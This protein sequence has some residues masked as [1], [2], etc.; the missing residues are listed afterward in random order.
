MRPSRK[1][2]PSLALFVV[3]ILLGSQ[4]QPMNSPLQQVNA[5]QQPANPDRILPKEEPA[6]VADHPVSKLTDKMIH[7]DGT[8][9][10]LIL[11]LPENAKTFLNDKSKPLRSALLQNMLNSDRVLISHMLL[12]QIY[13]PKHSFNKDL[14]EYPD[15]VSA[16]DLFDWSNSID[17]DEDENIIRTGDG[18]YINAL[19]NALLNADLKEIDLLGNPL[20]EPFFTYNSLKIDMETNAPKVDPYLARVFLSRWR[21]YLNDLDAKK[22]TK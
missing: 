5:T 1:M 22:E 13:N 14:P 3:G 8:Y 12:T 11:K 21:Q 18:V 9:L 20:P 19:D 15:P 16:V 2:L 4:F 7:W 6:T 17:V 10:G